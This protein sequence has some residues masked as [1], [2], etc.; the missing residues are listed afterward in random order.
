MISADKSAVA[1]GRRAQRNRR[2]NQPGYDPLSRRAK[3]LAD[4]FWER[5]MKLAEALAPD[6]PTDQEPLTDHETWMLLEGV[7]TSLSPMLWD[8]PDALDDLYRLRKM[9]M[10]QLA[11]EGLKIRSRMLRK[12]QNML[13]DPAITPENPEFQKR[14]ERLKRA[15]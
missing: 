9:F 13:P 7:G 12:E 1:H 11:N 10:P 2:P 6:E 14:I 8:D 15:S 4:M 5:A 3:L